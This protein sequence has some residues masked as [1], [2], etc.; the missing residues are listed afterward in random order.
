MFNILYMILITLIST[1]IVGSVIGYIIHRIMHSRLVRFKLIKKIAR[2]HNM[3]HALYNPN[4]FE[5]SSYRSSGKDDSAFVFVPIITIGVLIYCLILWFVY[6]TWWLILI[7]IIEGIIVGYLNDKIHEWFHI[8]N[9][10]LNRFSWFKKLK[11]LHWL[12]HKSPKTN[13]GIIWFGLDRLFFTFK[14]E[15]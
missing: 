8:E 13:F 4:D 6:Q 9:H 1:F 5:S 2:S 10:Y 12:H 3:H 11:E 15:Y 14:N 7:A